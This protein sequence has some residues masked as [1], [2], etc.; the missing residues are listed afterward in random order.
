[1]FYETLLLTQSQGLANVDEPGMK[2]SRY[3]GVK[4]PV[5]GDPTPA[6]CQSV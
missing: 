5:A 1:M 3:G 2:P 6:A 4:R